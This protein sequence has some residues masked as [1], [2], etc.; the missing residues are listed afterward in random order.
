[1]CHGVAGRDRLD[2]IMLWKTVAIRLEKSSERGENV[3]L[4]CL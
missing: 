4:I 3:V 1:M 2:I